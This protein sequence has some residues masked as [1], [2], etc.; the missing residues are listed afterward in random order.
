MFRLLGWL[1][2]AV[3]AIFVAVSS[4]VVA[5]QVRS[6]LA[7]HGVGFPPGATAAA[8]AAFASLAMRRQ[9]DANAAVS[10]TE[11]AMAYDAYQSE[12]LASSA[13]GLII[14]S[15]TGKADAGLRESLLRSA[16]KL[17]RRSSLIASESI[18]AAGL[19]G[20][21]KT[22]FLW[23]SRAMLTNTKLRSAYVGAMAEAT[24]RNGSVAALTPVLGTDPDWSQYYWRAVLSRPNSLANAAKLRTAI[25]AAPWGKRDVRTTDRRLAEALAR[26]GQFDA[27]HQLGVGLGQ[28][29]PLAS[30]RANLLNNGDFARQPVLPPIDWQLATSG[31]LGASISPQDDR[32]AISAIAGANGYVARQI[33][34]LVP[35][36]YNVG[37]ELTSNADMRGSE[38]TIRL[39]CA[40]RGQ[41]GQNAQSI[42]LEEGRKAG[43]FSIA[44]SPCRWYW[45][46]VNVSVADDASGFDASLL[47]ISLTRSAGN[48]A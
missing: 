31:S 18:N 15:K 44:P 48:G 38:A 9:Q 27:A 46:S 3:A 2:A 43:T 35:G 25:A 7:A 33:V 45:F 24:A 26:T 11:Y 29:Q 22:F 20:D 14:A 40:E 28:A 1:A 10:R 39:T 5:N 42:A 34:Q 30:A 47:A 41:A 8:N 36:N 37:W 16:G 4:Y 19:R 21:D 32:L 12:P 23:L 13:I 6:P 17:T